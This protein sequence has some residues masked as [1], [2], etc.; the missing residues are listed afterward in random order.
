MVRGRK[1]PENGVELT[2]QTFEVK[3]VP[4]CYSRV[5][6]F[7]SDPSDLVVR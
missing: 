2:T 7:H 4:L 5:K 6:T 3:I 1:T